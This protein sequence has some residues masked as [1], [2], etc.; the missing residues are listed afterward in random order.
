VAVLRNILQLFITFE[1]PIGAESAPTLNII[2]KK[3][4]EA[5]SLKEKCRIMQPIS[6]LYKHLTADFLSVALK[7][8][9]A[10]NNRW[11]HGLNAVTLQNECLYWTVSNQLSLG[12]RKGF[13][14][15]RQ[16]TQIKPMKRVPNF[17]FL[18]YI[19]LRFKR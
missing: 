7:F 12:I 3:T 1:S 11:V 10:M 17:T 19:Y 2:K 13:A 18:Y 8:L 9:I 5:V 6:D 14:I 4:D 16:L 15:S